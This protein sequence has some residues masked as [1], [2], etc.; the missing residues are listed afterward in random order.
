MN[1]K[2]M[3]RH[4]ACMPLALGLAGSLA[5]PAY[6]VTF[7]A[8]EIEGQFDSTFS[9]GASWALRGADSR[10]VGEN[11]GGKGLA[12][13]TDDGRLN[14]KK[15]ETFSKIFKG[16]HELELK[17]G[18]SGVFVR[19]KYW[20]DFELKDE[21]RLVRDIDDH[22][23]EEG[24][25]SSGGQLL[26]AFLYHNYMIA[27][28]PGTVRL[29]RQV[30]SWGESTFIQGG[31]NSINP[32]DVS[33]FRRPG[34]EIKEGLI[35]V[36]MFYLSQAIT[37]NLSAEGFY[38]LGWQQTVI[39]NCGT[40]FSQNDFVPDG[41][42]GVPVGPNLTGNPAAMA[43]LTPFGIN[44][45]R[46]GIVVPR[47]GDDDARDSGQFGVA[48]RWMVPSLDTEFGAY[49]INYHSRQPYVN[50]YSSPNADNLNF[51]P[52]LCGNL[53]I[54]DPGACA[55]ALGPAL[56]DLAVAYRLGTSKYQVTYP[57]DIRLYGLS[58]ATTL[59]TGTAL[60]GEISYRPNMPLQL[61]AVDQVSASSG[62]PALS[63]LLSSGAYPVADDA[64]IQGYQRKPVTQAQVTAVQFFDQVMGADRVTLIGEVGAVH[65]GNL[66]GKGG[67]RYGR[68]PVFGQGALY[69]DNSLCQA[70]NSPATARNCNS[71]GF[72]TDFSWGYRMRAIWEYSNLIPS[73]TL[74]P[75]IA[76]SHD[77]EG[78]A[79]EPGFNEGSKAVSLGI[80]ADYRNTYSAS[81]S[82]TD[83]FDGRYNTNV[84]RDFVAFSVGMS[85]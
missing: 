18:D 6:G 27:D 58:F 70:S 79:P 8:G 25:K 73:V 66:E 9:L 44:L 53:G 55:G 14:F 16:L 78:Y 15:G 19:G 61:N 59:P 49:F 82:V 83:F 71:H 11:N 5:V 10:L 24:A 60:S 23:R 26:D 64:L 43:A 75:N 33:A 69:P 76:W 29:G 85:F 28:L 7:N 50:S 37:D 12:T 67:L 36:N 41:C 31:I 57:E 17:Y 63:P 65:V 40:F 56:N 3:F 38:Q 77:V 42:N 48:L 47:L 81:L 74:K 46:Q 35:P 32:V 1:H 22:G 39:D 51:V 4:R 20:Y 62:I 84:D 13:G 30:V 80:D 2:P 52:Q 34:A 45:S 54:G 68:D 72:T 21:H